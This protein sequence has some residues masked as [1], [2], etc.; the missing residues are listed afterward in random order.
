MEAVPRG[1]LRG[2][3]VL[4]RP[5]GSEGGAHPLF[6][7]INVVGRG[8]GPLFDADS[9]LSPVHLRCEI[10]GTRFVVRDAGSLNGVFL[11]LTEEIGRASCRERV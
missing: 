4:V 3:L 2:R 9:F 1:A 11:K 7:G 8:S 6:E 10:A 5:D